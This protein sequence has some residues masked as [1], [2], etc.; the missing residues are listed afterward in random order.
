MYIM[1]ISIGT[2]N[3]YKMCAFLAVCVVYEIKI[4]I[5]LYNWN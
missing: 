3:Y 4:I 1:F 2:R 5:I